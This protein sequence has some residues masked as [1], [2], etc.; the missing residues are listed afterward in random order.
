MSLAKALT[1]KL[2][3]YD[4]E[5]SLGS[6]IRAR[7]IGPLMDMIRAAHREHGRVDIIDIGG[8]Q[9]YWTIVPER[10]LDEHR[11]SITIVNIPGETPPRDEGRYRYVEADGCDLSR[12][13]DGSFHIAHS[14]SVIE[15]VGDWQ[16]MTRFASELSRVS[17]RYFVQTPN[18]WFVLEPH[19]MTPFFHWL[20]EPT[21]VWLVRNFQ[22]G[23]WKRADSL[24]EAV[25]I[26]ES[27][28]LLSRRMFQTLFADGTVHTER[29]LGLPKSLIAMKG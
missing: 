28:R 9:R 2:T 14:N 22:L 12:F 26:V 15:H 25:R 18:F 17:Q 20:P 6:R 7:R 5:T 3:N 23:Q 24:D 27:A 8:T 21:R 16:R 4:S 1:D 29:L 10:F 13:A 11:V 19:F